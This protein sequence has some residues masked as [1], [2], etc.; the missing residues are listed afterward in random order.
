MSSPEPAMPAASTA[1]RESEDTASLRGDFLSAIGWMGL[2]IAIL[3]GS[4]TMDRLEKQGIN[5]YTIP[6]LLPGL[7]GIA[8]TILG[9]LLAAR[10]WRPHSLTSTANRVPA[11]RAERKRLL[12]VLG[13]CLS[14]GVVLVG[15][16]LPFWLAAAI[17]VSTAILSLQ[18]QQRKS[19]GQKL[20]ARMVVTAVAIGLGAGIIITI[21]FQEI[22]LVRLP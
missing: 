11:D 6:G 19:S 21:V 18:Y 4:V 20:S 1:A 13:L 7:L 16:G 17:F 8:M 2:G 5:P 10:S 22:F 15:H 9:A 14:F 12:L 3:I